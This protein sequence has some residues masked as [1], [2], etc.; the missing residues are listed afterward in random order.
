M[1]VNLGAGKVTF[2]MTDEARRAMHPLTPI[3]DSYR[4]PDWVNVDHFPMPGID[5]VF[6]LFA[7]PWPLDDNC[8][9]EIWCSH[10]IEHIP[11]EVRPAA[12][13]D[14]YDTPFMARWQELASLDGFFAFFAECYRILKPGGKLT[15]HA[16]YAWSMEAMQD[17]THTR[18]I[19]PQTFHYL[20]AG[21]SSGAHYD[22]HLPFAFTG[23]A[24][25]AQVNPKYANMP[26]DEMFEA[27]LTN[28]NVIRQLSIELFPV[29]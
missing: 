8:A 12:P 9:E 22:Y 5:K 21:A 27:S 15:I 13:Y 23:G 4:E 2:P 7:Y 25:Q 28:L 1:R 19:V 26:T 3:P 18:Y 14:S 16:P 17:P 29:N 24:L 20:T 11:H 10:I 6:D